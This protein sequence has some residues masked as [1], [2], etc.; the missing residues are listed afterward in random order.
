MTMTS[1]KNKIGEAMINAGNNLTSQ[2]EKIANK[3]P[4]IAKQSILNIDL[5][6]PKGTGFD[7]TRVR[8]TVRFK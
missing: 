4:S 2:G 1:V 8:Q 3:N 5:A 6:A 7:Y